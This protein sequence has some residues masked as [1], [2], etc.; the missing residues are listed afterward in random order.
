MEEQTQRSDVC[1]FKELTWDLQ[2]KKSGEPT[3]CLKLPSACYLLNHKDD[4]NQETCLRMKTIQTLYMYIYIYIVF[5]WCT[6]HVILGF[7]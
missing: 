3:D 7:H 2:D 6:L 4:K 5:F 1:A